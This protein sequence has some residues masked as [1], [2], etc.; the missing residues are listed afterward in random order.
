MSKTTAVALAT[1]LLLTISIAAAPVYAEAQPEAAAQA[2]SKQAQAETPKGQPGD[3]AD[4]IGARIFLK[5]MAFESMPGRT[6][7]LAEKPLYSA[8]AEEVIIRDFFQDREGGFFLDVGAAWAVKA[9]NTYYLEKNLGWTGIGIDALIDYASEWEEL[10]PNSKFANYLITDKSGGEGVFYKSE[11]LGL[12]STKKGMA[13]GGLFGGSSE[14][15]EIRVPMIT[16]NDL[17]DQEGVKKVDLVSMDI[18]GHEPNAFAGFDI[19]RFAPELLVVEGKNEWV[20]T[21]LQEHGYVQIER[22]KQFD[23]V[24]GYYARAEQIDQ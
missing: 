13:K 18:E 20:K 17:L 8:F 3:L 14:P 11:S 21:Y 9:S 22:Y 24:N 1:A 10:R 16:L 15:E 12:S 7:I 23:S 2:D 5:K 6:G 19:E 4:T